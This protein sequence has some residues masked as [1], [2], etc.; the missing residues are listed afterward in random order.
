MGYMLEICGIY[1]GCMCDVSRM[2]VDY[3]WIYVGY[4]WHMSRIHA[5]YV[6]DICGICRGHMASATV[7]DSVSESESVAFA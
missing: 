7:S 3:D 5:G 6:Q 1:V 2:Y 4:M